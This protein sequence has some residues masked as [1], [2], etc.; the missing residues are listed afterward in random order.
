LGW[1]YYCDRKVPKKQHIK[2]LSQKKD[3]MV[4]KTE[5]KLTLGQKAA[6]IRKNIQKRQQELLDIAIYFPSEENTKN[7]ISFLQKNISDPASTFAAYT[8][9]TVNKN[10]DINY[11]LKRPVN[12]IGTR[13]FNDNLNQI[14]DQKIKNLHKKYGLFFIYRS[15]CPYC[16]AYAPIIKRFAQDNNLM[17]KA[18][19]MDGGILSEFPNSKINNGRF[20]VP[21]VPAT[22]LWDNEKKEASIIGYAAFSE[23]ELKD[24]IFKEI[25]VKPEDNF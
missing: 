19:S 3:N 21:Q 4:R 7:Y 1:N 23:N 17:I 9:R 6:S 18:I 14:K 22:I 8:E 2:P 12:N 11:S 15:D 13:I 24:R 20:N 16:H 25:F 10:P 5:E